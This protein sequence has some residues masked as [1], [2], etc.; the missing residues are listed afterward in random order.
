[1]ASSKYWETCPITREKSI[2][3]SRSGCHV[4]SVPTMQN[5]HPPN[6]ERNKLCATNT[7]ACD[8]KMVARKGGYCKKRVPLVKRHKTPKMLWRRMCFVKQLNFLMFSWDRCPKLTKRCGNVHND[9]IKSY[10][11]LTGWEPVNT[12]PIVQDNP[13]WVIIQ[14]D[15][16][17]G[18]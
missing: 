18:A 11:G 17:F 16:I 14:Y 10:S 1:M 4:F 3:S 2:E 7:F 6:Q 12:E 15:T 13:E 9:K 5:A 8:S